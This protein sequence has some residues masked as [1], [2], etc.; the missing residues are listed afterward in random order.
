MIRAEDKE[1]EISLFNF[2]PKECEHRNLKTEK[3]Y[4]DNE[5][6]NYSYCTN[7]KICRNA[8]EAY[9]KF[10]SKESDEER[11]KEIFRRAEERKER[12]KEQTDINNARGAGQEE[13]QTHY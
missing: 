1:V 9:E 10:L 2:C 6:S 3:L 8:A 11:A 5:I 12:R 13:E 4:S 7:Y